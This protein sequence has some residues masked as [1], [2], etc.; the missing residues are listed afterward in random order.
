MISFCPAN[1]TEADTR[2]KCEMFTRLSYDNRKDSLPVID[3]KRNTYKNH[4]CARCHSIMLKELTFY[5]I[6]FKCDLPVPK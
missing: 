5:N 4:Y 3:H 1:W 6:Q 2:G